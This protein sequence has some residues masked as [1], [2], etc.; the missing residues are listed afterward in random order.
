VPELLADGGGHAVA[1]HRVAEL[2]AAHAIIPSDGGFSPTLEKLVTAFSL[3]AEGPP[4]AA[5]D[6]VGTGSPAAVK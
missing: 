4:A 5:A 3:S 2:P 1:C 6:I